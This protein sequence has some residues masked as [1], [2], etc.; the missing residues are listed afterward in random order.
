MNADLMI[1]IAF[2]IYVVLGSLVVVA[3][4]PRNV[5]RDQENEVDGDRVDSGVKP[6]DVALPNPFEQLAGAER[7]DEMRSWPYGEYVRA[8]RPFR[9]PRVRQ[10]A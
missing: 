10:E 6:H 7:S 1:T 5:P 3:L 2:C 9:K 4:A 8:R